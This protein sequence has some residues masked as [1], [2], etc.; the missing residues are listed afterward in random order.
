MKTC[1]PF[2]ILPHLTIPASSPSPLPPPSLPPLTQSFHFDSSRSR[3]TNL[4]ATLGC[5]T[6]FFFLLRPLHL[7]LPQLRKPILHR[8]AWTVSTHPYE[9]ALTLSSGSLHRL[10]ACSRL[11]QCPELSLSNLWICL[12]FDG[13]Y[14]ILF[15][16]PQL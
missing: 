1:R 15:S 6:L 16:C 13:S 7:L 4:L 8:Y 14:T 12:S 9:L 10:A 2:T 5:P 3:L 11:G